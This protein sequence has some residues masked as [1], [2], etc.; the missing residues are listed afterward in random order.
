MK[1]FDTRNFSS[2]CIPRRIARYNHC[3]RSPSKHNHLDPHHLPNTR[4]IFALNT[5]SRRSMIC[6]ATSASSTPSSHQLLIVGPGVL[7]SY[8]GKLWLDKYGPGTVT[9][10]TN[11]PNN[12]EKLKQ[13]G[14]TPRTKAE[15]D[16]TQNFPFVAYAAPPSGSED[17]P[18]DIK[19]AL[20]L[21]DGTG[22]FL[23][24][25]SAS[26]FNVDDGSHCNEDT[27]IAPLGK[28]ERLDALLL[29]EKTVLNARGCVL[30]LAGLYHKTRGAHSFFLKQ[31]E[32][33]RWGGYT[34]NLIHYEDAASLSAAILM[35]QGNSKEDLY[36]SAVFLGCDGNP[37][38]F[39]DMMSV[40]EE[41]GVLPGKVSFTGQE[42][43][44]KG[45]RMNNEK[46]RKQLGWQPRH[47]SI[48]SF[49]IMGGDDVY[50]SGWE[51]PSGASHD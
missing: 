8:L 46:T 15:A 13:I 24:T 20:S 50:S 28:S 37:V 25:S 41:S 30:R 45:K 7:G 51:A 44:S 6:S 14:I 21:W 19:S 40:I 49:F 23:F 35:G 32:V 2:I 12:H 18:E 22:N 38:T 4:Q 16:P 11:T 9:G 36:R 1:A 31:G 47:S 5:I 29:A 48:E 43:P 17:Y 26:V 27:P 3:F 33:N 34:I 39:T 10:E 42:S